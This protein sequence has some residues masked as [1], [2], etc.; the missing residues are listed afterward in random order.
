MN[1]NYK[2]IYFISFK[3]NLN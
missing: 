1:I 2:S 3:L